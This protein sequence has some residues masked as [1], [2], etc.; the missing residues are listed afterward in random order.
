MARSRSSS[1][2]ARRSPLPRTHVG[3]RGT[4]KAAAFSKGWPTRASRVSSC[5]SGFLRA[6]RSHHRTLKILTSMDIIA[7]EISRYLD[8]LVPERPAELREMERIAES[9]NF[10]IIGPASGQLCY[11]VARLIGARRIFELASGYGY[12]TAWFACA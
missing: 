3:P 6:R 2:T 8:D 10:P 11:L 4:C 1:R 5:G 7:P 9:T 12:S